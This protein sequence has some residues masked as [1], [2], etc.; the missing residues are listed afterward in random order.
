MY[1]FSGAFMM[2]NN[3]LKIGQTLFTSAQIREKVK[4]LADRI[5][6]D[7][8]GKEVLLICILKGAV[9]FASDLARE[10]KIPVN[11]DFMTIS[12][13]GKNSSSSG[14]V[15]I[16][17]DLD[18]NIEGKH[19]LIVEDIIDTGLTLAYLV[20]LFKTR[21]PADIRVC[22]FLNKQT[23]RSHAH[24]D[25]DYE[26]FRIPDLFVVGYGLDCMEQHRF[27]PDI[28]TVEIN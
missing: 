1:F 24:I 10:L 27:L 22:T 20:K 6:K 19:V 9:V 25:I 15:K 8:E 7:Y 2:N 23:K 26:G 16:T 17:K 5:N 13:Y 21:N 14:I 11:I 12:S 18:E 28:C 3:G 4:E